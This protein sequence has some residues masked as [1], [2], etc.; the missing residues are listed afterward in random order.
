MANLVIRTVSAEDLAPREI[1]LSKGL[2]DGGWLIG[3]AETQDFLKEQGV[4]KAEI[5]SHLY[6]YTT[7]FGFHG[8]ISSGVMWAS[9][10]SYMN[11]A[12]E[13]NFFFKLVQKHLRKLVNK[14][15]AEKLS[16]FG[17]SPEKFVPSVESC[18]ICSFSENA[19]QLS[20][21]RGYAQGG[22]SLGVPRVAIESAR[23]DHG[24]HL[25]KCIYDEAIAER[26]ALHL[27]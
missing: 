15:N 23:D 21:W 1:D 10:Y 5:P 18:F 12:Q 19:D 27:A 7:S 4:L 3:G 22:Y 17:L 9:N 8:I 24:F 14:G 16:D 11:D 2:F 25:A 26:V 20:Q 6:H 13:T